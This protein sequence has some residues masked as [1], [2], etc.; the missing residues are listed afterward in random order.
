MK[1][2]NRGAESAKNDTQE[3]VEAVQQQRSQMLGRLR[4]LQLAARLLAQGESDRLAR[5]NP[6]DARLAAF[7]KISSTLRDR[8]SVL[9]TELE[10]AA[11]RT[12]PV[13]KTDA[14]IHGRVT[15]DVQ[16]AAG[17]L[18][19]MLVRADGSPVEGVKPVVADE[20]GYY[21]FVIDPA[22]A[23]NLPSEA[24]LT[25]AV[26]QDENTIV[27]AAAGSFTLATGKVEVR[28]LPLTDAELKRLNLRE[29]MAPPPVKART[30]PGKKG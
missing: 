14:L 29:T 13:T 7:S 15:D 4:D 3:I 6:A 30:T 8:V 28:D 1:I 27:P 18:T 25:V 24:R 20:A 23:A 10:V 16:R 17:K 2:L 12:P 22:T 19:V 21:A 9:D 5:K 26:K 11:I